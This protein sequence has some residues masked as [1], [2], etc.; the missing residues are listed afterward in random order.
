[1]GLEKNSIPLVYG[2]GGV[3]KKIKETTYRIL[4][5]QQLCNFWVSDY[6]H[7]WSLDKL[8]AMKF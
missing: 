5:T 6:N 1:M 8:F 2:G 7:L 3:E 4:Q